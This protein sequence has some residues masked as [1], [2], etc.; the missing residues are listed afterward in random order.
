M[1]LLPKT[2]PAPEKMKMIG[3]LWQESKSEEPIKT[4]PKPVKRLVKAVIKKRQT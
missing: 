2:I 4:K 3:K 1:Q